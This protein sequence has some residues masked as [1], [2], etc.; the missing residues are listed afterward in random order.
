[1]E[2]IGAFDAKTRLSELLERTAQG[3][4]F[5]ITKHGRPVG[6]IVPPDA[7][8]DPDEIAAAL[9]RLR[10]FRGAL[11]GMTREEFLN[12]KHEGHGS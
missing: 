12:L 6:K 8:R 1:M 5:L 10:V 3:E 9:R 4:S 2:T 11:K 7:V